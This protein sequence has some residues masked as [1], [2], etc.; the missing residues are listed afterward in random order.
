MCLMCFIQR[1]IELYLIVSFC[2]TNEF[3][4]SYQF[5]YRFDFKSTFI[6]VSVKLRLQVID[7]PMNPFIG[8]LLQYDFQLS[9]KDL[10]MPAELRE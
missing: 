6:S 7:T 2:G 8:L 3:E 10:R 1:N 5:W 9:H 4:C